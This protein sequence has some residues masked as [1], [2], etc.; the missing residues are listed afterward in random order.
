M[1][2]AWRSVRR[3]PILPAS[4]PFDQDAGPLV[5]RLAQFALDDDLRDVRPTIVGGY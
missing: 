1:V 3:A 2:G 5:S 4:N